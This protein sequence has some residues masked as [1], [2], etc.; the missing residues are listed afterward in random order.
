MT[1]DDECPLCGKEY[2]GKWEMDTEQSMDTRGKLYF[3]VTTDGVFIHG[4]K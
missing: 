4:R 1:Q 2:L 3:C